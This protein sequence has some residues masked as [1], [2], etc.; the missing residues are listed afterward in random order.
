MAL[1]EA[2]S[3]TEI[4]YFDHFTVT[5]Y[6]DMKLLIQIFLDALSPPLLL[7]IACA[8]AGLSQIASSNSMLLAP[9]GSYVPYKF[10]SLGP[11]KSY[12]P[13]CFQNWRIINVQAD[14]IDTHI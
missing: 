1:L 13:T 4:K 11:S 5:A 14:V 10:S 7:Q 9:T 3:L 6:L 2:G 12:S 8:H